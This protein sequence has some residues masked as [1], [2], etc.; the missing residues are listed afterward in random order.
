MTALQK[1]IIAAA[2]SF[3]AS[4]TS[5]EYLAFV[6]E[7]GIVTW[8]KVSY[9]SNYTATDASE[10]TFSD[11][12][13]APDELGAW[14]DLDL[15]G[16]P[17]LTARVYGENFYVQLNTGVAPSGGDYP[18][19]CC[20][21]T[22]RRFGRN[23]GGDYTDVDVF[24]IL[25]TIFDGVANIDSNTGKNY[26][27]ANHAFDITTIDDTDIAIIDTVILDPLLSGAKAD[28]IVFVNMAT[29]N[30]LQTAD[31]DDYFSWYRKVGTTSKTSSDSIYKIYYEDNGNVEQYHQNGV[32][33]FLHGDGT[34]VL[35][36]THKDHGEAIL[37]KCPYTYS[38]ANGGGKILQRFGS[39]SHT[40]GLSTSD[41]SITALHNLYH[42]AY[43]DG[44]ET[45]SIFV[46]TQ[47]G[48][49]L[50]Q[51]FEFEINLVEEPTD[52]YDDTVFDTTYKS[53]TLSYSTGT[54]GG[55]R[56][57]GTGVWLVGN[58]GIVAVDSSSA[59]KI[60]ALNNQNDTISTN[61]T[62]RKLFQGPPHEDDHHRGGD[63]DSSSEHV[64]DSFVFVS[65]D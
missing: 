37:V 6:P 47:T 40:F 45:M 39:P 34:W 38:S 25:Q 48:S 30:V 61:S 35:G 11:V 14:Y 42:T 18:G 43:P 52:S 36:V 23:D 32:T 15:G 5:S 65:I 24:D 10:V 64:Y 46:N 26:A 1:Y 62:F 53:A 29:G 56:P 50:S 8:Q 58:Y 57:V 49:S 41:G 12:T 60:E 20:A 13:S 59:A 28:A 44:T 31:G 3:V 9:P 16:T 4:D 2:A 7:T 33:R 51:V 63:D 22:V 54:W 17:E 19:G 21:D 55:C 27:Y